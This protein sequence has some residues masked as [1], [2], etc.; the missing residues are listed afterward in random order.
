MKSPIKIIKYGSSE[1]IHYYLVQTYRYEG[2]TFYIGI[3]LEHNRLLFFLTTNFQ[4]PIGIIN[5]DE[6]ENL[7]DIP[8]I[9]RSVSTTV[10][11]QAYKAIKQ[12]CFPDDISWP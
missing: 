9:E 3:D 2:F 5:F 12:N 1:K 11:L 6:E 4:N 7:I 10:A 8:G